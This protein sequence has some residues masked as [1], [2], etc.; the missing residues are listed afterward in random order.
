VLS[1]NSDLREQLQMLGIVTSC[2]DSVS[3]IFTFD[4]DKIIT[5]RTER[6]AN[7]MYHDS[8]L[9]LHNMEAQY[10]RR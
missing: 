2:G 3:P 1:C 5:G 7:F 10:V 8:L 6:V 9:A 4:K